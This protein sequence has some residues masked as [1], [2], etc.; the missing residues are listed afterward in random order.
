MLKLI[1]S[2][3]LFIVSLASYAQ[4]FQLPTANRALFDADGG[5]DRFFA[6]TAGKTWTSGCFGCVRTEGWQL[7][8]G[9][10]IRCVQRDKRNEPTDPVMASAAG[11]VAY[12]NR[13]PS[14][15]NYGNYLILQH[16]IDGLEVYT[17]YAHLQEI[18]ADLRPGI[19]V[20]AGETIGMMGRT[21]NTRQG[22]S[23]DRAHVH[24]EVNLFINEKFPA[25]YKK[26]YP[27]QRNDHGQWNGQN[28]LGIDPRAI[29]LAQQ[30][31]GSKFN[32]AQLLRAQPELCRV[33]VRDIN[34]PWLT[35]YAPLLESNPRA[36]KEGIAGYEL[37]LNFIGIPIT[38]I[39]R[40]ASELN[41]KASV[42]L[43]SVNEAEYQKNPCRK[44]VTKRSGRWALATNGENLISLLTF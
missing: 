39:P 11:T 9:L 28:M 26:Q 12:A 31:Q 36:T 35:R 7:H 2:A 38:I 17:T 1:C 18:S 30:E 33:V 24:F 44:L 13:K 5:A 14:L 27:K 3:S 22:I 40:A 43:I 21:A 41:S 29:F 10:D 20:K 4:P 34:F 6:P 16:N 25:W 19:T 42:Q 15:S 32:L 8:E 37:V 23:K